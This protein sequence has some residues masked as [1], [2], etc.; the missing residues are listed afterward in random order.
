LP[1][2]YHWVFMKLDSHEIY[3]SQA[4]KMII[5]MLENPHEEDSEIAW[6]NAMEKLGLKQIK[7]E[8]EINKIVVEVIAENQQ[9]AQDVKNGEAKA[10]GF[11]V[12][13]VMAKS[14]GKANP[15]VAQKIIKVQLGL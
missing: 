15:Q 9:A 5:H 6:E 10:I 2:M 1:D 14:Q 11:L 4:K 8:T 3:S 7:D 12:G 13:Q